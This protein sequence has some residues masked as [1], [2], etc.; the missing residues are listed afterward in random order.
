MFTGCESELILGGTPPTLLLY[1]AAVRLCPFLY[2]APG[3][4]GG[5][6]LSLSF[7][8]LTGI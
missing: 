6:A 8:A 1:S 2:S 4:S 7:L 5:T 3:D